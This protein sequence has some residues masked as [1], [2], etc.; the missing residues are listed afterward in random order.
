MN[1]K[2]IA[3]ITGLFFAL[4]LSISTIFL[5]ILNKWNGFGIYQLNKSYLI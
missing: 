2:K 1:I 4:D 3:L 5:Q